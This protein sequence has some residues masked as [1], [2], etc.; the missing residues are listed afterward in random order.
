MRIIT[1]ANFDGYQI[2]NLMKKMHSC[3]HT[4]PRKADPPVAEGERR[5]LSKFGSNQQAS[6]VKPGGQLTPT[7]AGKIGIVV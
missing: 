2:L 5:V 7:L 6:Q 3:C 1:S 4:T